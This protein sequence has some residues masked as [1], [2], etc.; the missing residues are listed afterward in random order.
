LH[1][2]LMGLKRPLAS[3]DTVNLTLK[4]DGGFVKTMDVPVISV[5]DE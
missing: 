3:G 2:M 5:L 1:L 4:F